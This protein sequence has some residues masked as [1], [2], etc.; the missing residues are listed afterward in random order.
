MKKFAL[1]DALTDVR[2]DRPITIYLRFFVLFCFLKKRGFKKQHLS[3]VRNVYKHGV[4]VC[5]MP[6]SAHTSDYATDCLPWY[7]SPLY[8]AHGCKRWG[9]LHTRQPKTS[10]MCMYSVGD[11][12]GDLTAH[13]SALTHC[14]LRRLTATPSSKIGTGVA[15]SW[16]V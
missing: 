12:S 13:V 7:P 10:Q 8:Q 4:S 1:R 9:L 11:V 15:V 2:T 16:S 14:C 3:G 6:L 5:S